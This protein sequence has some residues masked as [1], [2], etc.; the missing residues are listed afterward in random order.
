MPDTYEI[1]TL[2]S[3][4]MCDSCK[5]IGRLGGSSYLTESCAVCGGSG[6]IQKNGRDKDQ[7]D[8]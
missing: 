5:G 2:P 8:S 6:R 4:L 3:T 1:P 7:S